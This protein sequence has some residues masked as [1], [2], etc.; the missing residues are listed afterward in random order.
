MLEPLL[1]GAGQSIDVRYRAALIT[2]FRF[3]APKAYEKESDYVATAEAF[4][5]TVILWAYPQPAT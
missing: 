4:A 1:V 2:P 5:N 3:W